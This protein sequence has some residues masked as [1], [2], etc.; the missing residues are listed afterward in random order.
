[1]AKSAAHQQRVVGY[2]DPKYKRLIQAE[3]KAESMSVSQIVTK[4]VK[5]YYDSLSENQRQAIIHKSKFSY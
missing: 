5:N 4:A 1:M 3:A 2:P